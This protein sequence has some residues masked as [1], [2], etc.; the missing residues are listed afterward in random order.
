MV[1]VTFVQFFLIQKLASIFQQYAGKFYILHKTYQRLEQ[2][3]GKFFF[4]LF[5]KLTTVNSAHAGKFCIVNSAHADK[6]CVSF[7]ITKKIKQK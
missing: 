6:F 2:S 7:L 3:A 1:I 4:L 5:T